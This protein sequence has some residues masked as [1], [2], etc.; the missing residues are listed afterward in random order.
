ML[1]RIDNEITIV[2]SF[3][4]VLSM[5]Q[6]CCW[7]NKVNGDQNKVEH[8]SVRC[9]NC[10]KEIVLYMDNMNTKYKDVITSF[11]LNTV[12]HH[13]GMSWIIEINKHL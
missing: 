13:V 12:L 6:I 1:Y 9:S 5:F 7:Y 4:N 8:I 2:Q 10:G 3:L 11:V